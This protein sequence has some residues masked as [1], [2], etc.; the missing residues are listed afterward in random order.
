[1]ATQGI[2]PETIAD[3]EEKG[4]DLAEEEDDEQEPTSLCVATVKSPLYDKQRFLESSQRALR[5][6]LAKVKEEIQ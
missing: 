3:P 5:E 6:K 1:M 2:M 4:E